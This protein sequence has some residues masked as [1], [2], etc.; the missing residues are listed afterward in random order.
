MTVQLSLPWLLLR[1]IPQRLQLSTDAVAIDGEKVFFLPS[2]NQAWTRV[3]GGGRPH[4]HGAGQRW[5]TAARSLGEKS[6][7][8]KSGG[9]RAGG[10]RPRTC[11]GQTSLDAFPGFDQCH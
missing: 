4:P 5:R 1:A 9:D 11:R 8:R 3:L 10:S 7:Y 2:Q 6:A